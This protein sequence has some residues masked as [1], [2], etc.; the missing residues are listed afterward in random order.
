MN[1]TLQIDRIS[2][3]DFPE[4]ANYVMKVEWTI[5]FTD[6]DGNTFTNGGGNNFDAPT[7]AEGITPY[8]E[9]TEAQVKQ[10]C[11]DKIVADGLLEYME[12]HA[13]EEIAKQNAVTPIEQAAPWA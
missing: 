13:A 11:E 8:N 3:Q 1:H 4:S 6:D 12:Q 9:L 5:T 2:T 10:W 7:T